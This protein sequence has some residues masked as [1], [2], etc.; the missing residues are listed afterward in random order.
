MQL[1]LSC[2]CA[3]KRTMQVAELIVYE[4]IMQKVW[5]LLL[6][7]FLGLPESEDLEELLQNGS[8]LLSPKKHKNTAVNIKV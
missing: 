5:S 6:A 7:V 8:T 4:F 2:S 1:K 3:F